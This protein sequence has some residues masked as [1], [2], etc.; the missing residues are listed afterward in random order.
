[1]RS[2]AAAASPSLPCN[3]DDILWRDEKAVSFQAGSKRCG[4]SWHH[5]GCDQRWI[6]GELPHLTSFDWSRTRHIVLTVDPGKFSSAQKSYQHVK[7]KRLISELIRK[8]KRG[9]K[10]KVGKAWVWKHKPI[11][12]THWRCYQEWHLDGRP[13]WH[14]LIEVKNIGWRSRIGS[15]RLSELWTPGRWV[16]E[17]YF[18]SPEHWRNMVG[19]FQKSG[20]WHS[21]KEHQ[22][23]L[24]EWSMNIPGLIIRRSTGKR[25]G[26]PQDR[27]AFDDYCKKALQENIDL[28]TGEILSGFK[29]KDNRGKLT[30]KQRFAECKKRSWIKISF[31]KGFIEGIFNIPYREVLARWKGS[32]IKK[33]GYIF[34]GSMEEVKEF[35]KRREKILKYDVKLPGLHKYCR[36]GSAAWIEAINL[37]VNHG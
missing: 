1:M 25:I 13:H 29:F 18:K 26:T 28:A 37:E 35:L 22:G 5:D 6:K 24:P 9:T 10:Y 36:V 32:Y 3:Y 4:S 11:T 34:R 33:L 31:A 27:D 19:D 21:E 16:Y 30:Y 14:L 20:Y 7:D 2:Q 12:I 8:L 23:T 17:T 15:D